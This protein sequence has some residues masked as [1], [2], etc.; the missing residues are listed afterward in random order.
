M[1]K[2]ENNLP[3]S[4]VFPVDLEY[5][6]KNY[7]PFICVCNF[8]NYN[9]YREIEKYLHVDEEEYFNKLKFKKRINSYLLGRYSAKKAISALL[10][11]I[12]LN[13]ICILN[14]IFNEPIVKVNS[15][16]PMV[17]IT[18]AKNIGA[19][20]GYFHECPMGIDVEQIDS[21]F[22]EF[23]KEHTTNSEMALIKNTS[24]NLTDGLFIIWAAK[25][26]ISKTIKTGFLSPIDIFEIDEIIFK[27]I[28][29]I[30]NYKNFPMF[31]SINFIIY[32]YVFSLTYPNKLSIKTDIY[33]MIK[34]INVFMY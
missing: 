12:N 31:S 1:D 13:D 14:G 18:H 11:N 15:F 27:N 23:L 3:R 30:C 4:V 6:H 26:S 20:V 34:K 22:N 33:N 25:E 2:L 24:I 21:S 7:R 29:F 10:N 9:N 16:S 17:S 28:Y 19:S 8:E 32:S 5:N